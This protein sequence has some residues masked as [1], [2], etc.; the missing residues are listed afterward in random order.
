MPTIQNTVKDAAGNLLNGTTNIDL[1]IF[2]GGSPSSFQGFV[3]L[4]SSSTD[5]TIN[6]DAT[7]NIVNGGWS[8]TVRGNAA[9]EDAY[10]G[11]VTT[12]YK[13]SET[14]NGVTRTYY[15]LAPNTSSTYWVGDL[16]AIDP[17]TFSSSVT[18]D[19]ISDVSATSPADGDILQY[20][21]SSQLWV[22]TSIPALTASVYKDVLQ[23]SAP[24]ILQPISGTMAT[25]IPYTFVIT[26]IYLHVDTPPLGASIFCNADITTS[27]GVTTPV[28][29]GSTDRRPRIAASAHNS[30]QGAPGSGDTAFGAAGS[31]LNIDINQTGVTPN[32]G[33]DLTVSVGIIYS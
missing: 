7:V 8:A 21:A 2:P 32:E 24:G 22:A 20:E 9:I 1:I 3:D 10:G 15:I 30:T 23:F 28:F 29:A 25:V 16:I 4:G 19:S 33:T 14:C 27:G 31:L 17:E 18:L 11:T 13:V 6:R 26:G 5:Y 12:Y